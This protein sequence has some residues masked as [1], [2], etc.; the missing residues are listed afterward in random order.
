MKMKSKHF[1]VIFFVL[2]FFSGIALGLTN[3]LSSGV[4]TSTD[5]LP[6]A[7]M[8]SNVLGDVEFTITTSI[9]CVDITVLNDI[10]WVASDLLY[11]LFKFDSL[12]GANLG[13]ISL[14]FRGF[15]ITTDGTNLYV[16]VAS[17]STNG[18]IFKL[19][20]DGT[21]L[22]SLT[23]PLNFGNIQGL[24]WDGSHLWATQYTPYRLIRINPNT[25]VIEKNFTLSGDT[26]GLTWFDNRLWGV[27]Y[28]SDVIRA[29]D[30]ETGD[31]LETFGTPVHHDRGLG[32]NGTHLL[33]GQYLDGTNLIYFVDY[34]TTVGEVFHVLNLNG[35]DI[36]CNGTHYFITSSFSNNVYVYLR[37][38]YTL[39]ETIALPF[40]PIGITV[41]GTSLY[42]SQQTATYNIYKYSFGGVLQV[43]FT[44]L[45][46]M[47][48]SLAY[49]GT[50]LWAMGSNNQL[51]K[52]N[53]SDLSQLA[54][55]NVGDL[56]GIT[57]DPI[58]NVLWGVH[59]GDHVIKQIDP[60]DG[61]ATGGYVSTAVPYG[62]SGLTF[63]GEYLLMTSTTTGNTY[64]I[65]IGF[66]GGGIPGFADLF[67][68]LALISLT[69]IVFLV[70][71]QQTFL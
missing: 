2:T 45:G 10:V 7:T 48:E 55:Y 69:C 64:K 70:K 63:D 9:D 23:I 18:T 19:K 32:S 25:G 62:E 42:I 17:G 3:N 37:G 6:D 58:N 29:F 4:I 54:E 1:G 51:Y 61:T 26:S 46:V 66:P 56:A 16:S 12:T 65:I 60:S 44:G 43:T 11:N 38:T 52:L 67:L 47:I 22:S 28:L 71:R 41:V 8:S 53:P 33:V 13:N 21:I 15:G 34:P 57:Y 31:I 30:P 39:T 68:Y 49:D 59:P 14:P 20:T 5:Q 24:A 35:K 36:A 27:E 50:N 40:Q